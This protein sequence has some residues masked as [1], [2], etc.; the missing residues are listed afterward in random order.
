MEI[1][2]FNQL[3]INERAEI[4]WASGKLI[5]SHCESHLTFLLYQLPNFYAEII[6]DTKKNCIT[7]VISFKQGH[8]LVIYASNFSADIISLSLK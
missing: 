5:D 4:V 7:N 8:R 3:N 6:Y 1:Y 2:E